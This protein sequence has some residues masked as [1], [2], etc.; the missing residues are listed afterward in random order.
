MNAQAEAW[1]TS[2]TITLD[3]RPELASGGDPL[4]GILESAVRIQPGQSL[5]VIAPFEPVPLYGVLGAHGFTHETAC[6]APDEWVVCF[7]RA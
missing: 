6:V 1:R 4:T 7:T 5:V 2:A 3:V